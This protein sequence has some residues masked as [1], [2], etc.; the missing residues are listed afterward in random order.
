[1]LE[2]LARQ[3]RRGAEP[4]VFFGMVYREDDLIK[5]YPIEFFTDWEVSP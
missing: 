2:Q 4:P 3:V 1:M 5:F